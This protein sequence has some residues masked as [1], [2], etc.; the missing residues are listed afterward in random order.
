MSRNYEEDSYISSLR[1]AIVSVLT[2]IISC[3]F[4][5]FLFIIQKILELLNNIGLEKRRVQYIKEL[6]TL[7]NATKYSMKQNNQERDEA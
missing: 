7:E 5:L 1:T 4:S 3:S 2:A 6:S